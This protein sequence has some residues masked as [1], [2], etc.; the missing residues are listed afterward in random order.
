MKW[1]KRTLALTL[2]VVWLGA[3]LLSVNAGTTTVSQAKAEYAAAAEAIQSGELLIGD[4]DQNGK[5]NT[6]DARLVLQF[7]ATRLAYTLHGAETLNTMPD[8]QELFSYLGTAYLLTDVDGN[9]RIN[10]TDARMILQYAAGRIDSFD[11]T[12][13]S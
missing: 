4:A 3:P 5:I 9:Y 10:T 12:D 8:D 2:C 1:F 6:T 11:R 13:L 7:A